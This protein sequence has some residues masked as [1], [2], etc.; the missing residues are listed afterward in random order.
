M[1]APGFLS[2]QRFEDLFAFPSPSGLF[3]S[4]LLHPLSLLIPFPILAGDFGSF[5]GWSWLFH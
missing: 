2:T 5:S 1:G 4:L 3:S